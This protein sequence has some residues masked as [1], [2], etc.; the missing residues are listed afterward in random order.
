MRREFKKPVCR[1]IVAN[2][3]DATGTSHCDGC[4][5]ALKPVRG[6]PG[7]Y[8]IDHTTAEGIVPEWKKFDPV[9]GKAVPLTAKEGQVLGMS[10]CHRPDEGGKTRR[11]T[12]AAARSKRLE[13]RAKGLSEPADRPIQSRGFQK[14][15]RRKRIELPELPRRKLYGGT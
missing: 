12:T 3:T 8:E 11:D 1:E 4:G 2:A 9:T 13:D 7:G 5:L 14:S 10:C 6:K 15:E